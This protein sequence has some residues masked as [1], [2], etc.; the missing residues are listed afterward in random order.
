[1]TVLKKKSKSKDQL[2]ATA[3]AFIYSL[4]HSLT[5]LAIWR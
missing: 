4:G 1:M 2:I 3:R 5:S